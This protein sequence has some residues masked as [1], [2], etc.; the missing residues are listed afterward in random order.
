MFKKKRKLRVK[1]RKRSE[2]VQ[3]EVGPIMLDG[4]PAA[5][6]SQARTHYCATRGL[7]PAAFPPWAGTTLLRQPGSAG[8]PLRLHIDAGLSADARST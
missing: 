8:L 6:Y 4:L 5:A 3:K 1:L 7:L 2:K